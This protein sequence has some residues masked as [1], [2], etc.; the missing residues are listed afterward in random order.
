MAK[1]QNMRMQTLAC[2]ILISFSM[3]GGGSIEPAPIPVMAAPS[4]QIDGAPSP[5]KLKLIR[6]FLDLIGVQHQLDTGSFLERYA[7]PGGPMWAVT[8]GEPLQEDLADGFRVRFEAL[9]IAYAKRRTAYQQD[10]EDHLNWEFT[11][12]EL[13][14]IVTF[15]GK[16]VGKHYLDGR[17]RMEAYTRNNTEEMDEDIVKEAL[18]GLKK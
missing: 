1:L 13:K 7:M 8:P 4:A 18:A 17:W 15:L 6:Q 11:E 14:E 2:A 12:D 10:Y 16:P 3:Q 5:T 9:K